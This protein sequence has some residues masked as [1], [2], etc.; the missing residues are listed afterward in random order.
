[1]SNKNVD[2]HAVV[3]SGAGAGGYGIFGSKGTLP[4]LIMEVDD[5]NEVLN[6]ST[7]RWCNPLP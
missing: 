3:V 2:E 6:S 5:M 1:M 4:E 7:N